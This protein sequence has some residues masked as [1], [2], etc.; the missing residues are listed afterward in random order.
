MQN[1]FPKGEGVFLLS[2]RM[3]GFFKSDERRAGGFCYDQMTLAFIVHCFSEMEFGPH[4]IRD[5]AMPPRPT[6]FCEAFGDFLPASARL[7]GS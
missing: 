7:H 5:D 2:H 1:T 4:T 6:A 3:N